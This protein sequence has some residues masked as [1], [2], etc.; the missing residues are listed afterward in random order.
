MPAATAGDKANADS[1]LPTT[2]LHPPN[3]AGH[4][5][6]ASTPPDRRRHGPGGTAGSAQSGQ[7]VAPGRPDR[8]RDGIG[9]GLGREYK[10]PRYDVRFPPR[11]RTHRRTSPGPG[12]CPPPASG[13]ARHYRTPDPRSPLPPA[14]ADGP[15]GS[16]RRYPDAGARRRRRRYAVSSHAPAR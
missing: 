4:D 13:P 5:E 6:T 8:F 16:A 7:T 15:A 14:G 2:P 3:A 1:P 10:G 9:N 11:E 12:D